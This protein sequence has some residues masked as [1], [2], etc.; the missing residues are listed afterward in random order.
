[1]GEGQVSVLLETVDRV[2]DS[3]TVNGIAVGA[4]MQD[5]SDVDGIVTA[6]DRAGIDRRVLSPP[7]FTYRYWNDADAG[8]RLCRLLNE[9]TAAV[10][11]AHP[12]RFLGLATVPL[13]DTEESIAELIRANEELG[14]VGLTLGTN[15]AGG[16][17]S[18]RVRWPLLGSA[19]ERNMP[20]LIHPDF[21]PNPR[22]GNYYLINVLGMPSESATTMSNML[23][24]GLF[25]EFPHLRV[26]FM[27]G[28]GSGPYLFGRWDAAFRLRPESRIHIDR[29]PTSLLDNVFCDTLTHSPTALAYLVEVLGERNVALGTDL[30]F[31]VQDPDPRAHL[32]RAPR[33]TKEQIA[34][35][36]RATP[37]RWLTGDDPA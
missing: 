30:P 11:D 8:L 3:I 16:N 31:D 25:I 15:V 17:V 24:S 19:T 6:T 26:V 12:D 21:V 23:F 34:V 22:L 2:T 37:V 36:E 33:L 20:V 10:V 27:H 1:M 32:R 28:G 13:Q 9:A 5:L 29:P 4:T 7:P 18:D 14:L 35:I